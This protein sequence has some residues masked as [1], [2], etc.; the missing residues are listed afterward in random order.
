MA[1]T[2]NVLIIDDHPLIVKAYHS[3]IKYLEKTNENYSFNTESANNCD[4]AN[5]KI[6]QLEKCSNASLVFLDISVPPSTDGKI[7]SGEDLGIIIRSKI[8]NAKIIVATTYTKNTRL[9]SI[10]KNINPDGFLIKT[11]L[12][13]EILTQAIE[14][15]IQDPPYYCKTVLKFLRKKTTNDIVLD[16]T[17]RVMLLELSK[18]ARMNELPEILN[19]SMAAIERRKRILKEKFRVDGKSDRVLFKVAEEEGFI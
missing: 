5:T 2:L 17:D 4:E 18:G 9:N 1:K 14:T 6:L 8:P 19:L 13:P 7:V 11:D 10:L 15:V 3:A 16:T 12:T